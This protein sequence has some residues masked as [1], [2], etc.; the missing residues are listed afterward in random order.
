M[1]LFPNFASTEQAAKYVRDNFPSAL[2]E[3]LALGPKLLPQDYHGLCSCFDLTMAMRY[4][5]DSNILGMVQAIFYACLQMMQLS[6]DFYVGS[7][8][9][10]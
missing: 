6:W 9:I 10:T 4:A 5:H 2:R 3:S 1:N 7:Q 8:W